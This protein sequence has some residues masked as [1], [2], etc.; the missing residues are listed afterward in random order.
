VEGNPAPQVAGRA[1]LVEGPIAVTVWAGG[2]AAVRVDDNE[3]GPLIPAMTRIA[4]KIRLHPGLGQLQPADRGKARIQVDLVT[5]TG[6]LGRNHWLFDL[7]GVPGVGDMMEINSG[8]EGI[9]VSID[10]KTTVMLPH[11]LVAKAARGEKPSDAL[12]DF[13]MA[14]DLP[15][16]ARSSRSAPTSR[17]GVTADQLFGSGPT[18]SSSRRSRCA[19]A[20]RCS[21]T[22]ATWHHRS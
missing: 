17:P 20:H 6:P 18:R 9:G 13:A 4:D 8:V 15:R 14:S 10:G 12:A 3:R 21:C 1:E 22:A 7:V 11:E 5:G 19:R 16:S 2:R